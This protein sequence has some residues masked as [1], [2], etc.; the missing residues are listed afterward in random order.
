MG[1]AKWE[2]ILTTFRVWVYL[3]LFPQDQ[4]PKIMLLPCSFIWL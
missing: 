3:E 1:F 2:L 4:K